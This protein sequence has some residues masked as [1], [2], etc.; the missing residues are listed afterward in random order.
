MRLLIFALLAA[1]A[2]GADL[3]TPLPTDPIPVFR[4][5]TVT[6]VAEK[7]TPG[8]A[9]ELT[10]TNRDTN[11]PANASG[12]IAITANPT[13]ETNL[14]F[15]VPPSLSF[16]RWEISVPAGVV[17]TSKP[18]MIAVRPR[19]PT[20]NTVAPQVLYPEQAK[21]FTA[22]GS[23]F[24][25]GPDDYYL[26]FLDAPSLVRCDPNARPPAPPASAPPCYT[27]KISEDRQQLTFKFAESADLLTFAGKR[28]FAI[29]V[30][31][32]DS[33]ASAVTF[34]RVAANTPRYW[35][36][37]ILAII[38]VI[39]YLMLRSG[40]SGSPDVDGSTYFLKA[41]FLDKATNTYSLS[42]CQ[43]YA[44][45]GA[46][47]LGYIYL[48]TA[49]S[50]IQGGMAFPDIPDGLPGIL[51]A[52]AGTTVL[53]AGITNSK[54]NK[55][56]G[57]VH[58]S[59][60]D[61]IAAGGVVAAERLQFVVWTIVGVVT[62]VRLVLLSDP[63]TINGLPEIPTGF[64]QLMGISS[65]GYLGGKLA[66]KA[67]PTISAVTASGD[68][69]LLTLQVK[70]IGLSQ[71]ATF[72]IGA[73]DVPLEKIQGDKHLPEI[74]QKDDTNN[75]AGIARLL[76]LVIAK[77]APAWL[78]ANVALTITNPDQ[79]E[80]VTH[81]TVTA[82]PLTLP[83]IPATPAPVEGTPAAEPAKAL[84]AAAGGSATGE[85][86]TGG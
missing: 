41:L 83:A 63:A 24:T 14:V 49:K 13:S 33:N 9:V 3:K 17:I 68:A 36:L 21:Q 16:G 66:R 75:E 22:I 78:G 18:V 67:G 48:A 61:F 70:G 53:A 73:D 62:F 29:S 84:S 77:P 76:K 69:N 12:P 64:L 40:E 82:A 81:Y 58:P 56:A 28:P 6:L 23:G 59:L 79:Q 26:H 25:E 43:F 20:I 5:D 37:A 8:T 74:L 31:G 7:L 85:S 86:S 65:A 1:N 71:N 46:S 4:G 57:E 35:A 39:I 44:W 45:T 72:S 38:I 51:L 27:V 32:V 15:A 50:M 47:I 2:S 19:V 54:G 80:A 60:A 55:G 11:P 42:Q 10:A 52:S 34:S 30:G